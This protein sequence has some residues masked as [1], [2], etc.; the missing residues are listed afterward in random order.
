M[1]IKRRFI[2][3]LLAFC[4]VLCM[5]LGACTAPSGNQNQA[6]TNNEANTVDPDPVI[7]EDPEN[8]TLTIQFNDIAKYAK[9]SSGIWE[10]LAY[11]FPDHAIYSVSGKGYVA[12]PVNKDLPLNKYDWSQ[13]TKALRGIDVSTFQGDISWSQVK[14]SGKVDFAIIRIGYRGYGNG[15]ARI[16]ADARFETNARNAYANG[17]PIGVYFATKAITVEEAKEEARWIV[18]QIS[19]KSYKVTWPVVIDLEPVTKGLDDRTYFLKPEERSAIVNAFSEIISEAGYTPMVYGNIGM[20]MTG[21]DIASIADIPKWFAMYFKQPHFPYAYQ[22]WQSS[23][24]GSI[25]GINGNVDIDYAMY[26][27]ANKRDVIEVEAQDGDQQDSG[28]TFQGQ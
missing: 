26:D 20:F 18:N 5:L 27:F 3:I 8:P 10:L 9:N 12:E 16:V 1:D 17:I 19:G 15:T 14:A 25:P 28:N 7:P 21:T 4:M 22:I 11:L 2:C 24:T 13:Y 23:E 6:N